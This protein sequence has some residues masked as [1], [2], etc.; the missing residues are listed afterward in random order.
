MKLSH[1]HP[2]LARCEHQGFTV[3]ES[4]LRELLRADLCLNDVA[5]ACG[6]GIQRQQ[7]QPGNGPHHNGA[8]PFGLSQVP[9]T[10]CASGRRGV[11]PV[12]LLL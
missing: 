1:K 7:L 4:L 12:G 3:F 5:A 8:R 11:A 2:R 10:T 9:R 6:G